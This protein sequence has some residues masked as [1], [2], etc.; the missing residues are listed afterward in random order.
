MTLAALE[1]AGLWLLPL[2]D[3]HLPSPNSSISRSDM[4]FMAPFVVGALY[5]LWGS[6]VTL[7]WSPDVPKPIP[8]VH[9][10]MSPGVSG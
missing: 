6:T 2:A 1:D 4:P 3:T 10:D 8:C 5:T 7:L 9:P